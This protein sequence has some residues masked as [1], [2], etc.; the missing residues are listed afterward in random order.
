MSACPL[1]LR[2]GFY[3][4]AKHHM[5]VVYFFFPILAARI[6]DI[7][8]QPGQHLM[9]GYP[10]RAPWLNPFVCYISYLNF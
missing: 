7:L 9:K 6:L 8:I 4:K 2:P 1:T 10:I 5:G 3:F